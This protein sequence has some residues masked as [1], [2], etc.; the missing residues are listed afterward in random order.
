MKTT[1]KTEQGRSGV[2]KTNERKWGKPLMDAGYTVIPNVIIEKQA[3]LGMDAV[4]FA[5]VVVLASHWWAAERPPY[6]S[7]GRIAAA[8]DVDVSVVRKRIT[9]MVKLGILERRARRRSGVPNEYLLAGLIEK[10]TPLALK[11][12]RLKEQRAKE[13]AELARRRGV[14]KAAHLRIVGK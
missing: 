6:P 12:R 3:A 2:V 5:I 1:K 4:D 11:K 13:D 10:A 7:K 14:P 8:L 9:K